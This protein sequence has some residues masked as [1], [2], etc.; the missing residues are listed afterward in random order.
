MDRL[1]CVVE[2]ITYC[3]EE[4]GYSV[5]RARAKGF[6]DLVTVVGNLAAVNVGSVL[7][8]SGQWKLDKKYGRQFMSAQW[9]EMLP[10]SVI[11][12]EKYL[13]SGLI[14]GVGP[15]FARRIVE[16]FGADTLAV[17]EDGP[18]KLINIP[19]IGEKRVS[20]IKKAWIE[21]K[22]IKTIMIFLQ[23]HN[24]SA[25][26]AVKIFKTYGNESIPIVK[27]NPYRLADDIWGIG[28]KTADSIAQKMGFAKDS[29]YR[30]RSGLMYVLNE[31]ANDG[32]CYAVRDELIEKANGI[33]EIEALV[34]SETIDK[35]IEA[36]DLA[37][38]PPDR[39]YLPPLW[40]SEKGVVQRLR[41]IMSTPRKQSG[42]DVEDSI[43]HAEKAAG[44]T[45]D[46]IQR[47]AICTASESK[48]MILTGGPGVGKTTTTKGIIAAFAE[49]GLS[50]LLAAPTGRAG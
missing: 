17:I 9:E 5:L 37:L 49:Q 10:A 23:D 3:N 26:H 40:Y 33:L 19:G 29:P 27:E 20:M 35:M 48:V 12:I 39:V 6:D 25:T 11:G 21:Q 42:I 7:L 15:K 45:Y 31:F 28:F 22:E 44:L 32:H 36:R 8:V 2:R 18:D 34:L 43:S 30:C 1:R 47:D 41:Q 4:N 46:E 38:E 14:K 16:Q 24:V 50:I 13:G